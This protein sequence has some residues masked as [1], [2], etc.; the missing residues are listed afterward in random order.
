MN[1]IPPFSNYSLAKLERLV[2]EGFEKIEREAARISKEP[3][4][5]DYPPESPI[6]AFDFQVL[7]AANIY[8]NQQK[9]NQ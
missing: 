5:W 1:I 4:V 3:Q 9:G 6:S 2:Q 8:L 7:V